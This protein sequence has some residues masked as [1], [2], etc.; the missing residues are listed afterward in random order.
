M[1]SP[2]LDNRVVRLAFQTPLSLRRSPAAALGLIRAGNPALAAIATDRGLG[3]GR[4]AVAQAAHRLFCGVTFKLDYLYAHGLPRR[5]TRLDG[6]I[7]ALAHTGL[8]GLHKFLPYRAWFRRELAPYLA[9][10]LGDARTRRMPFW[11]GRRLPSI[12]ID[13]V[14]GRG[15]YTDEIHRILTLE[16]VERT[17]IN[18]FGRTEADR[19]GLDACAS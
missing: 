10:V 2:F 7:A 11:D 15:N 5:L 6:A 14:E 16:A 12:V 4:N 8:V 13:H 1:R 17:L 18:G 19:L 9:Q 3:F